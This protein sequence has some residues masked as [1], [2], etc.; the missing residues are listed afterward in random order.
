MGSL[1][2]SQQ[3]TPVVVDSCSEGPY[4]DVVGRPGLEPHGERVGEPGTEPCGDTVGMELGTGD[5]GDEARSCTVSV[6]P[7]VEPYGDRDRDE[8]L[9]KS[10]TETHGDTESGKYQT[11]LKLTDFTRNQNVKNG[12]SR[13][14]ER[15]SPK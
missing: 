5:S 11:S 9:L 10:S 6:E 14:D 8:R 15:N 4:K 2:H 1:L 3:P 13:A 7:D 12:C